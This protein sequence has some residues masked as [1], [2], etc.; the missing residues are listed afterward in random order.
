M[1]TRS[2]H[3]FVGLFVLISSILLAMFAVWLAKSDVDRSLATYQ[4]VFSGSVQGLQEGNAVQYRGVP[5][6]RV[7]QI[8][9]DPEDVGQVLATIEVDAG[10]PI[11]SD[12]EAELV[13]QG[14]TGLSNIEL[15]GSSNESP[16]LIDVAQND[17]PRI[18]ADASAIEQVFDSTPQLLARAVDLLERLSLLASKENV[19]SASDILSDLESVTSTL[20]ENRENLQTFLGEASQAS[21]GVARMVDETGDSLDRVGALAQTL[22]QLVEE[23]GDTGA[24]ALTGLD[25]ASQ[26]FKNLAWRMDR[27]L[28]SLQRPLDDF[29]QSG[30]YEFS[31]MVREM[32]QLVA[33]L[34]RISKEFERDPAGFLIGGSQ[35]GFTPQ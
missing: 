18:V 35:R 32:R 1:E 29:G 6:G 23:V 22:N 25:E 10:T 7:R 9:I 27:T 20:A 31:E 14:I 5:V 17:P 24:A 11:K 34:S 21:R 2:S 16:L 3:F 15:K 33:S 13:L 12:T 26:A 19:A 4:I 28:E 8:G 30:L